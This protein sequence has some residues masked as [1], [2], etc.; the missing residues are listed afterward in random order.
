MVD[1]GNCKFTAKANFAEAAGAS[2]VLIINNQKGGRILFLNIMSWKFLVF[3]FPVSFAHEFVIIYDKDYLDLPGFIYTH[4]LLILILY[5]FLYSELYKMVCE[6]DETDLDIQI[7]TVLLPQDA[8]A[9][10]ERMLSN[11]SSGKYSISSRVIRMYSISYRMM[12]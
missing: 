9:S 12:I 3:Q 5:A 11:S 4:D 8:G 2:A 7:P 6:P 10:L 1:R